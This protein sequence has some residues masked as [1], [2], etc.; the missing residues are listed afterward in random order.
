MLCCIVVTD[1]GRSD[2]VEHGIV[3]DEGRSDAVERGIVTDEER[4]CV[5][6]L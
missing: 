1:E 4:C 6:S 2:A 3:T 5:A